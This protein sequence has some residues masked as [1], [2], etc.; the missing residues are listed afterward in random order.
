MQTPERISTKI[1]EK[2]AAREHADPLD[3]DDRLYDVIDPGSLDNLVDDTGQESTQTPVEIEFQCC[4]YSIVVNSTRE[5]A[6][7]D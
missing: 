7:H 5:V 4:G 2:V 6:L 1:V 3:L